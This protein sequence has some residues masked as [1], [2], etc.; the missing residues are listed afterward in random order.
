MCGFEMRTQDG[1]VVK[2]VSKEKEQARREHEM[3]IQQGRM[4]GLVEHITDDGN[5]LFLRR[6]QS[7]RLILA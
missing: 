1:R 4:T 6:P 7:M 5:D 2:A 3:A